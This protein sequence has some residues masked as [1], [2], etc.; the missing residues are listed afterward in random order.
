[1]SGTDSGVTSVGF[2]VLDERHGFLRGPSYEA[3][4]SVSPHPSSV[5]RSV[6]APDSLGIK[7]AETSN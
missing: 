1:M 3:T 6:R 4:L 5:C 2:A 7:A